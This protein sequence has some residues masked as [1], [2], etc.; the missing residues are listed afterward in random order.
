MCGETKG[1]PTDSTG[2]R[3]SIIRNSAVVKRDGEAIPAIDNHPACSAEARLSKD[4]TGAIFFIVA[5]G[6]SRVVNLQMNFYRKKNVDTHLK[7]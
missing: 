6:T 1:I 2:A 4:G 7:I 3:G 5:G